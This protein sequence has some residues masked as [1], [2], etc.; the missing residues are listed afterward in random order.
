MGVGGVL[1]GAGWGGVGGR[2]VLGWQARWVWVAALAGSVVVP[3]AAWFGWPGIGGGSGGVIVEAMAAVVPEAYLIEPQAASSVAEAVNRVLPVLW[4]AS[5][6]AVVAVIVSALVRLRR[7]RAGWRREVVDGIPVLLSRDE[8]PAALGFWRGAIVVPEWAL[9]LNAR[10]RRLMLLHEEEHVRAGDPRLL[11]IALL[12]PVL[13]PWNP[14][15]WWQLR[16]L[17][18]AMELDCDGRVLRRTPDVRGYGAL[19]LEVVRRK[20]AGHLVVAAFMGPRPFMERR[21]LM[22]A[23]SQ[24]GASRVRAWLGFVAAAGLVVAAC[25]APEPTRAARGDG[26]QRLVG[27]T[28]EAASSIDGAGLAGF[29]PLSPDLTRPE[30]MNRLEIARA[31]EQNYPLHLRDAG[32]GGTAVV[33]FWIDDRGDVAQVQLAASSGHEVLDAAAVMVAEQMRFTPA[34]DGGAPVAVVVEI[35]I[36]F[37]VKTAA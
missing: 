31:L 1:G 3:A 27:Q 26:A 19:L 9:S 8:G 15:V 16:R 10:L 32:I 37:R 12:G 11:L 21:I 36:A 34:R 7:A 29:R 4:V 22:L 17:R 33:R 35:P 18:Q 28:T 20:G 25:E 23:R 14:V 13:M 24:A 6:L 30:L 2:G 5:S